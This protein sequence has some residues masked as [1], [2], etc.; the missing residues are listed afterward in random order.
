M[1]DQMLFMRIASVLATI[2]KDKQITIRGRDTLGT[3]VRIMEMR[4]DVL[5]QIIDKT[6][7]ERTLVIKLFGKQSESITDPQMILQVMKLIADYSRTS[8][9]ETIR[10][11]ANFIATSM[12]THNIPAAA[13]EPHFLPP[14][15]AAKA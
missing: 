6:F 7:T 9:M 2:Q 12:S 15:R 1:Q 10:E 4:R 11:Q 13:L 8:P 5:M 3:I 14:V